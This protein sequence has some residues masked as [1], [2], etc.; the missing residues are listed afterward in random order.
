MAA[1]GLETCTG[2]NGL[3]VQCA[4]ES[5]ANAPSWRAK[6][7]LWGEAWIGRI[8]EDGDVSEGTHAT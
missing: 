3:T 5:A 7:A 6:G 2:F 1:C 4:D 8:G